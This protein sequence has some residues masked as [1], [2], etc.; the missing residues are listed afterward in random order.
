MNAERYTFVAPIEIPTIRGGRCGFFDVVTKDDG[1]F[2]LVWRPLEDW[3]AIIRQS[4][5]EHGRLVR[6]LRNDVLTLPQLG[7]V[8]L[9]FEQCIAVED[10]ARLYPDWDER[11]WK[12]AQQP[13]IPPVRK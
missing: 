11:D 6:T 7:Q 5:G 9:I 12:L 13:A 4:T 1:G 8:T 10:G 2:K 3:P